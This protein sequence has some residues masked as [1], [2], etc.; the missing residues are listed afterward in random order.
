MLQIGRDWLLRLAARRTA[1]GGAVGVEVAPELVGPEG[2]GV[3][4]AAGGD[5]AGGRSVVAVLTSRAVRDRA[6][7][8]TDGP[9]LEVRHLSV[10]FGVLRA[11]DNLDL[12]VGR[13]EIVGLIGSNGAGKT[14]VMNAIG[15]FV[16]S[17]GTIRVLGADVH[18]LS[19]ARRARLGL[20][21]TFQ[22]AELFGDLTVRETV[23]LACEQAEHSSVPTVMLGLPRQHRRERAVM[24]EA[25]EIV[26]FLQ[27][28]EAANQFVN[29]L[30]TGTRRVVELGCLIA[31]GA[32]VL[33]LDEPTAGLSQAEAESFVPL[34]LDVRQ[35][36]GASLLLIEHDM[37]VVMGVSH[38][39]YCLDAGQL[40]SAGTP[41]EVRADPLVLESYLG[42]DPRAPRPQ[43]QVDPQAG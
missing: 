27:L 14:T 20:G 40:L 31:S 6:R 4:G 8:I 37:G 24:A 23:A 34:I 33:C 41:D 3:D 26:S 25:D 2:A 17:Q 19:P 1:A 42:T 22:G 13:D 10:D 16:P 18:H 12:E 7:A 5:G 9:A 36:L 30:S 43:A 28:G 38:R 35:A 15:G 32:S 29:E 21:R 11:V 39:L